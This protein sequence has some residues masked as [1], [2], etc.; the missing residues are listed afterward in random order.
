[1]KTKRIDF[2]YLIAFMLANIGAAISQPPQLGISPNPE[3]NA[4]CPNENITYTISN[5][6]GT[7]HSITVTNGAVIQDN[8]DGILIVNWPDNGAAGSITVTRN[9]SGC[10]GVAPGQTWS[11]PIKTLA[12]ATPTI[13]GPL[14][15]NGPPAG[16]VNSV[17]YTAQLNWPFRGTNDPDPFPVTS[18]DWTLPTG[19]ANNTTPATSPTINVI[20][21]IGGGGNITATGKTTCGSGALNS[22]IA[23]QAVNRTLSAPCPI[24]AQKLSEQCGEPGT[25]FFT[26]SSQPDG[27]ASNNPQWSWSLPQGWSFNGPSNSQVINVNTDGQHGG[28]VTATFSDYGVSASCPLNI[29]LVIVTPGTFIIGNDR[30]CETQ[31]YALSGSLPAGASATWAIS[32]SSAPIT[33]LSGTG[34]SATL[35]PVNGVDAGSTATLTFTVS[36]CGLTNTL[37]KSI[38]VGRP[39]IYGQTIDGTP[40]ASQDVCPGWHILVA[41]VN[42]DDS[43]PPCMTWELVDN[44][45]I[46]PHSLYYGGCNWATVYLNPMNSAPAFVKVT[47]DNE[48]G[49]TSSYFY[50]YPILPDCKE[51]YY[52]SIYPNPAGSILNLEV[53]F[54]DGKNEAIPLSIGHVQLINL[55]GVTILDLPGT[56]SQAVAVD[57]SS[58]PNGLYVVRAQV[59]NQWLTETV[60]ISKN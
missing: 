34:T 3:A 25:N 35:T 60:Q 53:L 19:W 54:D 44:V 28:N 1:M 29:P 38:F 2:F 45:G 4:V 57:L 8:D 13:T 41:Q 11:A 43:D 50:L 15:P 18:F 31:T 39:E 26:A 59:G 20:T 52:F 17:N 42:G 46:P 36:G 24:I 10:S 16:F 30:L 22:I 56:D 33:P 12:L 9:P 14:A 55:M 21:N 47:A 58:V 23:T 32:P 7:C 48:C 37:P 51:N 6:N 49:P 40:G 5:Y 27:Y